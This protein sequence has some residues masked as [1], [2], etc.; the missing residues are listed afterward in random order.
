MA[1]NVPGRHRVI[2]DVDTGTDDAGALWCAATHPRFELVAALAGWGNST[3]EHTVRNTL[4]VLRAADSQVPVHA[5]FDGP[6]GPAP[7]SFGAEVVMGADGLGG[8]G[9][10]PPEGAVA[11]AEPGAEALV[12]LARAEPGALTLVAVAPLTTV[13]VALELEPQLPSLLRHLV[14]MGG[15]V[16]VG[17]NVTAV[18]EANI[19]HDP[20]AAA[21][22]IEA[23]GA[24]EA[25]G[26][27]DAPM[28][29]PLD[30]T[31]RAPL[32]EIE[33]AAVAR[34]PHPGAALVHR[35]WTAIWH[36]GKYELHAD[37]PGEWPCH[38]LTALWA[39]VD[40]GCHD[41]FTGPLTIDTGES[42]AWG[43]TVLDR[44]P[45]SDATSA[46]V[47]SVA[48]GIDAERYRAGVR[49][50]LEGGRGWDGSL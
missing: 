42:A 46:P 38:D 18:A 30:A 25:L 19:A 2:L 8:V 3:R 4:A 36:T 11:E 1:E 32:T 16:A 7:I 33:L 39:L 27:G 43:A 6:S 22:V 20:G 41:W 13:A 29:V 21:R 14:V 49:K 24:P 23:F 17:G 50:W 9:V 10:S 45:W 37:N 12:R 47:W 48:V 15:A 5:G 40:P 28:L 26:G 35:V 34:S 31:L 44:R